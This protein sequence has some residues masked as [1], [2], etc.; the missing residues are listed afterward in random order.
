MIQGG[1]ANRPFWNLSERSRP[2]RRR[3]RPL[4]RS[5][6]TASTCI[7]SNGRLRTS[8]VH[9]VAQATEPLLGSG[10]C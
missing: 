1:N 4:G 7:H 5:L 10:M 2:L 3:G 8:V 9:A 6:A